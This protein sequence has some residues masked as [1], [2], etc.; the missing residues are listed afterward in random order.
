LCTFLLAPLVGA[1]GQADQ[2]AGQDADWQIDSDAGSR[3]PGVDPSAISQDLTIVSDAA[4]RP[5]AEALL[6][7]FEREGY[8]GLGAVVP[9]EQARGQSGRGA[10]RNRAIVRLVTVER[11]EAAAPDDGA[12]GGGAAS[13]GSTDD[14]AVVVP[15]ARRSVVFT[16]GESIP[17]GVSVS[18]RDLPTLLR[19]AA[20]WAELNSRWPSEPIIR[21]MPAQED[22]MR[23]LLER[24]I[25]AGGRVGGRVV[26]HP[27]ARISALR[28][29]P[30]GLAVTE[31]L[32]ARRFPELPRLEV[33]GIAATDAT[34][35]DGSYPLTWL[36]VLTVERAALDE[37]P[38]A[39]A[40][41]VFTASYAAEEITALG[42]YPLPPWQSADALLQALNEEF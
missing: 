11:G 38:A 26:A 35:R 41:S 39:E 27:S 1:A 42:W 22:T 34:I 5:L 13:D 23:K 29:H 6:Q 9:E 31:Y 15:L 36:T 24:A 2:S 17:A 12:D 37:Q 16:L 10:S 20:V 30:S 21:L 40:F 3:L 25:S 28:E 18:K 32:A 19:H 7:R 33:D 4:T 14:G 8:R